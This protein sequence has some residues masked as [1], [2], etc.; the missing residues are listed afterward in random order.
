[1]LVFLEK[2]PSRSRSGALLC[3]FEVESSAFLREVTT[4]HT[5]S[6]AHTQG[7]GGVSSTPLAL[8]AEILQPKDLSIRK[9]I[10][11]NPVPSEND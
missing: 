10:G 7:F 11:V 6:G 1:M 5:P 4:H 2:P 3:W 9:R 8:T